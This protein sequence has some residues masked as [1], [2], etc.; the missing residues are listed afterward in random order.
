MTDLYPIGVVPYICRKGGYTSTPK[1]AASV[2]SST[3]YYTPVVYT[4]VFAPS[5]SISNNG[6]S[7]EYGY[8]Y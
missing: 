6:V 8:S 1:Y 2:P 4:G 7:P 3:D 5:D